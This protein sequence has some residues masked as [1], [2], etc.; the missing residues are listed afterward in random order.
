MVARQSYPRIQNVTDV[1]TRESLR[2]L[3][4]RIHAVEGREN[5]PAV[6]RANLDAGANR[7]TNLV[8][9]TSA[10]DAVTR[11]YG[12]ANYGP[13]VQRVFLE[14]GGGSDINVQNLKGVLA[15]P[16]PM[17]IEVIP[18]NESLPPTTLYSANKVIFFRGVMYYLDDTTNP[19]TWIP[20]STAAAIFTGTHQE[21]LD[22]FTPATLPRNLNFWETDYHILYRI[23]LDAND[24]KQWQVMESLGFM[25]DLFSARPLAADLNNANDA[26]DY[27]GMWF[28]ATDRGDQAWRFTGVK[29]FS[30]W[31]LQQDYGEPMDGT[32]SPDQKPTLTTNDDGFRF[33]STDFNREYIWSGTAWADAPTAPPRFEIGFFTGTP[34]P[35]T[36]W[37]LCDGSSVTRSTAV[38]GTQGAFAVPSLTAANRF[39]QSGAAAGAT[40][41]SA[42]HTHGVSG[43]T[44]SASPGTGGPSDTTTVQSGAGETVASDTH[45]HT[46]D[47]HSHGA[48]SLSADSADGR[49]PWY[50]AIPFI[51]L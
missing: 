36:G 14:A 10:Q 25:R 24:N 1:E 4:D 41:G 20:L 43:S 46:V 11:A 22:D 50:Q 21:R 29:G 51:R 9:P 34:E 8:D 6:L 33:F 48:G 44:G 17:G 38:G 47:S 18:D 31:V 15:D 26:T 23:G 7:L 39:I 28:R 30:T 19:G 40:G 42:T 32:L 2:L 5:N 37:Q 13:S 45:D 49:P 16:Q 12:D 27:D 35:S 3:W